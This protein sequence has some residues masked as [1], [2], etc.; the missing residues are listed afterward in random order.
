ML[1]WVLFSRIVVWLFST[2]LYFLSQLLFA[3][4]TAHTATLYNFLHTRC[5]VWSRSAILVVV[6]YFAAIISLHANQH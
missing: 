1:S 5:D 6:S 2:S 4:N 3:L